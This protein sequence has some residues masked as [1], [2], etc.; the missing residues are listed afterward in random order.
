MGKAGFSAHRFAAVLCSTGTPAAFVHPGEAA[1]GDLGIIGPEDCLFAFLH[2][3]KDPRGGGMVELSRHLGP[4]KVVAV[5][6]HPESDLR[7]ISDI[8][9]DMGEITW[10][11]RP[12]QCGVN[13]PSRL[14]R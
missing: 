8:I 14:T 13:V 5:T 3:W 6:S 11:S 1:H 4:H 10:G 9:I 12:V 7:L 2:F